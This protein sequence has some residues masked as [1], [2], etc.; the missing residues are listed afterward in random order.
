VG[1]AGRN[2]LRL[3]FG[4]LT[5]AR[6]PPPGGLERPVP[7]RAMALAPLAGLVPGAAAA[8]LVGVA[9]LLRLPPS[10]GGVLTVGAYA[11][12][13]RAL[14]LDGLADTADGL[15]ASY[16]RER[17]LAVMRR[18]DTG[19]SGLAAVVL[20][21]LLQVALAEQVIARSVD[22][23]AGEPLGWLRTAVV[24]LAVAVAARV[25]VP[26]ACRRGVPAAR[27]DGL[28]ATVAGSV[29]PVLL[30]AS[31]IG[32]AAGCSLLARV[33]GFPWWAGVLAVALATVSAALVVRRAVSRFG[34]ITGDV[35]GATVEVG[36][37]AALLALALSR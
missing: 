13:T 18:G 19:P 22:R 21:L 20:V 8:L 17:A 3:A 10:V 31:L 7:G 29:P 27:P 5:A 36:T 25:A 32:S 1:D 4:T 37:A 30:G 33:G 16:D 12:S 34:G 6:V 2:A 9:L 24:L 26:V 28:G 23:M 15:A 11:L 14:H 35:L